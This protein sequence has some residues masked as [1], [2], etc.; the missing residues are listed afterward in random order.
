MA[1]GDRVPHWLEKW[2]ALTLD[3][4][5][6]EQ[7]ILPEQLC[8]LPSPAFYTPVAAEIEARGASS[9]QFRE[10]GRIQHADLFHTYA[11]GPCVPA[12]PQM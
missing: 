3:F 9:S 4:V 8:A 12:L 1:S 11:A 5:K 10:R 6:A 2:V 7:R